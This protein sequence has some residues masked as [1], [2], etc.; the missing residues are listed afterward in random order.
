MCFCYIAEDIEY[1][2]P[3]CPTEMKIK[4]GISKTPNDRLKEYKRSS[5]GYMHIKQYEFESETE[6]RKK[7]ENHF[8]KE[9]KF[10]GRLKSE[11]AYVKADDFYHIIKSFENLT[12]LKS[13]IKIEPSLRQE[14][15]KKFAEKHLD[16]HIKKSPILKD[17]RIYRQPER[18]EY[19]IL[20]PSQT[21][22]SLTIDY[23]DSVRQVNIIATENFYNV[24]KHAYRRDIKRKL[25]LK[26]SDK[27][28]KITFF[29]KTKKV[30]N[31]FV[32]NESIARNLINSLEN[33]YNYVNRV[34]W[35]QK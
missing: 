2:N 30:S 8:K 17:M 19:T 13:I 7:G 3:N 14:I 21:S 4:F 5:P 15:Y 26:F 20:Y 16:K 34:L 33:L 28:K 29:V 35:L 12:G 18:K 1:I 22:N 27:R 31:N 25:N 11:V 24:I 6:A 23:A 9:F 10:V 32:I